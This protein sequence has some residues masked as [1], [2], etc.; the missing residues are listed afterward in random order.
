MSVERASERCA[1]AELPRASDLG[2]R[3]NML[4]RSQ[5]ENMRNWLTGAGDAGRGQGLHAKCLA[6]LD[7]VYG[8]PVI[9]NRYMNQNMT[10]AALVLR[11]FSVY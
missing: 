2:A 3:G 6:S 9:S 7:C 8:G 10:Q 5:W 4:A 1:G 11:K